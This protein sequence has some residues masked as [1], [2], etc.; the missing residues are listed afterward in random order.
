ML[1]P[2]PPGGNDAG[3]VV[4]GVGLVLTKDAEAVL[5][6]QQELARLAGSALPLPS[7]HL[8]HLIQRRPVVREGFRTVREDL[9]RAGQLALKLHVS[10]PVFLGMPPATIMS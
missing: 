1:Q 2:L 6:L 9:V 8:L 7:A 3:K 10:L 5:L 4:Y